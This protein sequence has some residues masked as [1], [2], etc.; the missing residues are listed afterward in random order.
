MQTYLKTKPVW[1]QMLLFFGMA[2][3]LFVIASFIGATVLSKTTGIGL[4]ELQNSAEWDLTNPA[5]RTYMRTMI[6]LQFVFLFTIPSLLFAYFS[7]PKPTQ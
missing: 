1:M 4:A 2:F 6:L 7:D 5:Y 3:G